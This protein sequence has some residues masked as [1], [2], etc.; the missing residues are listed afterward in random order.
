MGVCVWLKFTNT[1]EGVKAL[2]DTGAGISLLPRRLYDVITKSQTTELRQ[3]DR[4]ITGAN[5]KSIECF[6]VAEVEFNIEGQAFR[7]DFYVCEDA[8]TVLLGR[9]FMKDAK[10]QLEPAANKIKIKGKR[11]TAYDIKGTRIKNTVNLIETITI[12]PGQERQV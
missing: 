1:K 11:V 2:L 12:K 9:K 3:A 5:S 10:I 4:K 6:G 8:V 7:H